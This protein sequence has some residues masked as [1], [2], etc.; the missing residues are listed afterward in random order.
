M[1]R[2]CI[3]SSF[4]RAANRGGGGAGSSST[5][6][7]ST[8]GWRVGGAGFAMEVVAFWALSHWA[9]PVATAGRGRPPVAASPVSKLSYTARNSSSSALVSFSFSIDSGPLGSGRLS[10]A[11]EK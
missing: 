2:F 6:S 8:G 4:T 3:S 11:D 1:R 10:I 5:S 9:V 7:A